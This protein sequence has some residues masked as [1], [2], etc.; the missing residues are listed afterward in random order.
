MGTI[1]EQI[2]EI[3]ERSAPWE[4]MSKLNV[5]DYRRCIAEMKKAHPFMDDAHIY[6]TQANVENYPYIV[7][8]LDVDGTEI[9]LMRRVSH[10]E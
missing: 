10:E 8:K 5:V 2:R 3:K 1:D 6:I 9:Q 7:V 4:E